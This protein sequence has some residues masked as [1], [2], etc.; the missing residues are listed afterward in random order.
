[1]K[2]DKIDN[3]EN[4]IGTNMSSIKARKGNPFEYDTAYILQQLGYEVNRIDDNTKGIDL[5]ATR[6]LTKFAIEC[7]FHKK[8]SW[9][10]IEKIFLKSEEYVKENLPKHETLFIFKANQQPVLIMER[11]WSGALTL[12]KFEDYFEQPWSKRPKGY[13]LWQHTK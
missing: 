1:M 13:K 2:F 10:S 11:H 8:F 3:F 6:Q 9:N 5:I 7:K 4:Q 12:L